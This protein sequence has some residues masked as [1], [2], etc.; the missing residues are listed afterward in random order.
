MLKV[1]S[2]IKWSQWHISQ[3]KMKLDGMM[4]LKVKYIIPMVNI[5][6]AVLLLSVPIDVI[7]LCGKVWIIKSRHYEGQAM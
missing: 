6:N 5:I 7:N 4:I 1:S 3:R 2:H